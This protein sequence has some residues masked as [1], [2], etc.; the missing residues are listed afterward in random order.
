MFAWYTL[1]APIIANGGR[2]GAER[3]GGCADGP[4]VRRMDCD[5][6]ENQT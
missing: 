2:R 5:H 1:A 4:P 6:T 3:P